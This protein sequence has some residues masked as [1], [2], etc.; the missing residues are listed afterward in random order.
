MSY[1]RWLMIMS[2]V[3][4]L[5][6]CQELKK[7]GSPPAMPPV[8][9]STISAV[10]KSIPVTFEFVGV[11]NG[12]HTIEIR[13]R[14][15]GVI[16]KISFTEGQLVKQGETLYIIDQRPFLAALDSAKAE[17][18][19]EE[20]HEWS[21]TRALER[22]KPIFEKN[23]ASRKDYDEA[24]AL[25]RTAKARVASAKAK[26]M[27]A[28]LNLDYTTI[29]SP[30]TGLSGESNYGEGALISS[31]GKFLTKITTIDPVAVNFHVSESDVLK[32]RREMQQHLLELPPDRNFD[33]Q[34]T[35]ADGT[36]FPALGKLDFTAPT[37]R[38]ETGTMMMRALFPNPDEVLR[39]GQFVRAK[40]IGAKRTNAIEIPQRAVLQGS[41]GMFVYLVK[42]NKAVEQIVEPGEWHDDNWII[43]SGLKDGDV[44]I[45]DG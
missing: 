5:S 11:V 14:V 3:T 2:I 39:P 35:L 24:V 43:L 36:I 40:L 18:A 30:I 37:F 8:D 22:L 1:Y 45:V 28:E 29:T 15:E 7:P 12:Y 17:L 38:P 21:A 25:G 16:V 13:S 6:G 10:S 20:S 27:Q 41:K 33:V 34:I 32:E 44:V 23:A 31:G 19:G 9:V 26:V 4:V 42:D